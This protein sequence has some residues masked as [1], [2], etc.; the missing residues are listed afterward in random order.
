MD[1]LLG[2]FSNLPEIVRAKSKAQ[3]ETG[4]RFTPAEAYNGPGDAYRHIVW[5]GLLANTL[6]EQAAKEAGDLHESRKLPLFGAMG[7]P[8]AEINMD[9][10]N[11]EIG[12]YIGKDAKDYQQILD[13]AKLINDYKL[14]QQYR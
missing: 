8:Q 2:I 9:L 12:R 5:Q 3:E 1:G 4:K 14:Y 6:G 13:R 10:K 11:N 7:H